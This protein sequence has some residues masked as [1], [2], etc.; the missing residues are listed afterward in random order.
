M[1]SKIT[2]EHSRNGANNQRNEMKYK[3]KFSY[4]N[5][6]LHK[7]SDSMKQGT[8]DK[9][10]RKDA[11]DFLYHTRHICLYIVYV[12]YMYLLNDCGVC[13]IV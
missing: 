13:C 6:R 4:H 1:A 7:A 12:L 2:R 9:E 3:P 10:N 11:M 8:I 5:L